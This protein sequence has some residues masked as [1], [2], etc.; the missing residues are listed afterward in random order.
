[1]I[2][3]LGIRERSESRE[4]TTLSLYATRSRA[5][6]GRLRPEPPDPVRTAFQR[7]RDRIIHTRAFRRLRHKTQVF[8]APQ[9][10]HYETRL[11]HTLEVAQ[12]ART[13]A[14]ALLLNEDLTE[15]ICLGHDLG[16]TPFGHLGEAVLN[17]LYP[18]GFR[19]AEQSLR[20]VD[21]L[22][23]GGKGLNLTWEVRDGILNHSK[24][25]ES[26]ASPGQGYAGTFE[27][28]I[29]RLCDSIAYIN[30]DIED[31]VRSGLITDSDLPV[32]AVNILGRTRSERVNN[33]VCDL[34][35]TSWVVSGLKNGPAPFIGMS[36]AV[37]TAMNDMRDFLFRRVYNVHSASGEG[38]K[39]RETLQC[40]YRYYLEHPAEVAEEDG[41]APGGDVEDT[42]K[43]VDYIAGMTDQFAFRAAA[44]LGLLKGGYDS[45]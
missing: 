19:H 35:A 22:E 36:K 39:A 3:D 17:A 13:T 37:L 24:G 1:L 41:V 8:I 43:M 33:M 26:I 30:H 27:G 12:I 23:N 32:A 2:D 42:R 16:H 44:E 21:R 5:S 18:G 34:I 45:G 20:V 4:E 25:R 40:L 29:C 28:E 7:D 9:G 11:T 15:A 38:V 6:R 31:S 14:R 10:D